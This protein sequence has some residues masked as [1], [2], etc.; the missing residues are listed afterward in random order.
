MVGYSA[1]RIVICADSLTAVAR[2]YLHFSVFGNFTR[3]FVLFFLEKSAFENFKSL[4][5]VLVLTSLVLTLNYHTCG[6]VSDSD[7]GTC[8]VDMLTACAA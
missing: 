5:L 1:L 7:C 6:Q 4:V 8:F 3:L 2:T